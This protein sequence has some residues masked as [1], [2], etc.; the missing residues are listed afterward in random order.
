MNSEAIIIITYLWQKYEMKNKTQNGNKYVKKVSLLEDNSVMNL[1][2]Y[3]RDKQGWGRD[4]AWIRE[5]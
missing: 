2:G 4:I 3:Q 5:E 1:V